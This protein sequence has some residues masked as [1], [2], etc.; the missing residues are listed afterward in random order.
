MHGNNNYLY[1]GIYKFKF[2]FG[3]NEFDHFYLQLYGIFRKHI[4]FL[5]TETI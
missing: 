3:L 5:F 1:L 4:F 2:V